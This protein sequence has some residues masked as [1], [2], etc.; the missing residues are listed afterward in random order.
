MLTSENHP[1]IVFLLTDDLDVP[2][3]AYMPHV[4]RLLTDEGVTLQPLLRQRFVV[5]PVA[6][7]DPARPVL[8]QHGRARATASGNGGFETAY[9]LG[10]EKSTIGT[11]LHDAGYRTAYIGKYLNA[12]PDYGE[13]HVRAARLGR[14]RQRG[15]SA[16]P[17]PS[18]T[19]RSTRTAHLVHY[20]NK[21]S[22]YGTDRLRR[23]RRSSSSGSRRASRSSSTS[24]CT[25]RISPRR[26]RRRTV[27]CSPTR[28]APR[29]PSFNERDEA[30]KPSWLRAA[31]RM[32]G[33]TGSAIS[34]RLYRD[35]HPVAAGRRPRRRHV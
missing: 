19:T 2:E 14:V 9:R 8:A 26:R 25:R 12:Y 17:T 24:T 21:P 3:M 16:I 33:K 4:R 27:N 7:D 31:C 28:R 23:T 1:N 22:D 30:G 35:R 11:W 5:L 32:R 15:R 29:T 6:H 18:T 10:I 34:T 13:R 20:G